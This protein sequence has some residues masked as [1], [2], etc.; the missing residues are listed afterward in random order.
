[1]LATVQ[2]FGTT[3]KM[4]SWWE[5]HICVLYAVTVDV[6]VGMTSFEK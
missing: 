6:G 2:R 4:S 5:I 3:V 1:M